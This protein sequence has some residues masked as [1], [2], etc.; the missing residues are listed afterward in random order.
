MNVIT[1]SLALA[2]ITALAFSTYG[3]SSPSDSS[4]DGRAEGVLVRPGTERSEP[5]V[6]ADVEL[7]RGGDFTLMVRTD[8]GREQLAGRWRSKD[9]RT[10]TI[11]IDDGFGTSADGTGTA[12]FTDDQLKRITLTGRDRRDA[13]RVSVVIPETDRRPDRPS[14]PGWGRPADREFKLIASGTMAIDDRRL[15]LESVTLKLRKNGDVTLDTKGG[16]VDSFKG[17]WDVSDRNRGDIRI[18]SSKRLG[19]MTGSAS[20]V[21]TGNKLRSITVDAEN[22]DGVVEINMPAR[23]TDGYDRDGA[24]Q[25]PERPNYRLDQPDDYTN[26]D[27]RGSGTMNIDGSDERIERIVLVEDNDRLTIR[28]YGRSASRMVQFDVDVSSSSSGR[29]SGD[30]KR[31]STMNGRTSG[32]VSVRYDRA[33]R[34]DFLEIRGRI[35]QRP[36]TVSYRGD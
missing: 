31:V 33:R 16:F 20:Y 23:G 34:V 6:Y 19:R 3:W 5:V 29:V 32:A 15:R 27:N 25:R 36:V 22:R 8:R 9:S 21:I 10:A 11:T 7:R 13:W 14:D 28:V 35:D 24:G 30:L 12:L 1:K 18:V 4:Y 2:G 26:D 17:T